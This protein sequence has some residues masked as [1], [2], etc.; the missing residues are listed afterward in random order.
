MQNISV[1]INSNRQFQREFEDILRKKYPKIKPS[2]FIQKTFDAFQTTTLVIAGAT[3]LIEIIQLIRSIQ[4]HHPDSK[5]K[6]E[7]KV[8]KTGKTLKIDAINA[9]I[10]IEKII[11]DFLSNEEK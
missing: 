4:K 3:L 7:L 5:T 2:I 1:T 8:G 6:I 10:N 9:D 11:G